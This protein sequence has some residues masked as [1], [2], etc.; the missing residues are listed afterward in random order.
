MP[1]NKA[2]DH[3]E[4]FYGVHYPAPI[5]RLEKFQQDATDQVTAIAISQIS[6]TLINGTLAVIHLLI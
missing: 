2:I 1:Q 5:C 4:T 3:S 6:A